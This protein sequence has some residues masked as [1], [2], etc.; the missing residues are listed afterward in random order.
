VEPWGSK[1]KQR[2][3]PMLFPH[4]PRSAAP[5]VGVIRGVLKIAYPH[6]NFPQLCYGCSCF[7]A[8]CSFA[9]T[10]PITGAETTAATLLPG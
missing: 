1:E 7:V 9:S 10:R 3:M 4:N 2:P 6:R 5:F 8:A